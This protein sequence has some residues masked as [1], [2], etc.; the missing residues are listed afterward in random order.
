MLLRALS[1]TLLSLALSGCAVKKVAINKLGDALASPGTTFS[2]DNDPE[3]VRDAVPFSLKLMES[4]LAENPRHRGLL[5]ATASGFTQYAY[6]YIQ[7]EADEAEDL[8]LA[9]ATALRLRA[10]RMYLRARDYGMRGL[11][12]RY[13]MIGAKLHAQPQTAVRVVTARDIA[14]L[15]WTAAAWGAAISVSKTDPEIIAD[16]PIVEALIDRALELDEKFDFGA[17][18]SFLIAYEGSRQGA[19]GTPEQRARAHF[20]R[21]MQLSGGFQA[22]P[23]VSL[24]E[25]V[26][27]QKQDRK[28]FQ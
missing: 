4:L 5:L 22:G 21:A 20:D 13:A 17:I 18:H 28:E 3:F 10:R 1:A 9:R 19:S 26:S 6:A 23:L 27:V 25:N 16:Q 15:Y 7:Q 12:T 24:A 2:A 8:N 14:L 11:E